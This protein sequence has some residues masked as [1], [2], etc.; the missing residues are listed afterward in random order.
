MMSEEDWGFIDDY[1]PLI[2]ETFQLCH[3]ID[4]LLLG[5]T[6]RLNSE[7]TGA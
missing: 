3:D 5:V 2:K 7:F 6:E 1:E 4:S